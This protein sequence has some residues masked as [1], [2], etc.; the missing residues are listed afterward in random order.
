MHVV[1]NMIN[2]GHFVQLH[3]ERLWGFLDLAL[4]HLETPESLGDSPPFLSLVTLV[5]LMYTEP[6]TRGSQT[7]VYP[8]EEMSPL[9]SPDPF[10]SRVFPLSPCKRTFQEQKYA[11]T[12]CSPSRPMCCH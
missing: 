8:L 5:T 10:P 9:T 1:E 11:L 4:M 3:F 2:W 12:Q 6:Q 7:F